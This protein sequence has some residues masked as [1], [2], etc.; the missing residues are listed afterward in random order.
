MWLSMSEN[1][2]ADRNAR[3][4]GFEIGRGQPLGETV[5]A[6]GDNP[7]NDPDWRDRVSFNHL[8]PLPAQ[9]HYDE[10]TLFKVYDALREDG[11]LTEKQ[12]RACIN[13][14][15]SRGILFREKIQPAPPG[16]PVMRGE[17]QEDNGNV[18]SF[19]PDVEPVS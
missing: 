3:A 9:E 2:E 4:Y 5:V 13:A 15:R 16:G 18:R 17:R 14:M 12:T 10:D 1:L 8:L 11:G 19:D 7:F 6:S